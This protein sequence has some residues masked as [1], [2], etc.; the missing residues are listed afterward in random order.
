MHCGINMGNMIKNLFVVVEKRL[1]YEIKNVIRVSATLAIS[2]SY[3]IIVRYMKV[4]FDCS[5]ETAHPTNGLKN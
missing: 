3:K 4:D 5:Q 1:K 2:L